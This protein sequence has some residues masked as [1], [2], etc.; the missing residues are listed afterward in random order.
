MSV[1][2]EHRTPEDAVDAIRR[3]GAGPWIDAVDRRHLDR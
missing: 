2:A 3:A 1:P